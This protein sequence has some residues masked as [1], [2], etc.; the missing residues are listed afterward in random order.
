MS[1]LC[2][3]QC[4]EGSFFSL[5]NVPSLHY[6]PKKLLEEVKELN[7][8]QYSP[9]LKVQYCEEFTTSASAQHQ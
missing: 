8:T 5:V 6:S 2:S 3:A 7:Y 4:R 1:T 9:L